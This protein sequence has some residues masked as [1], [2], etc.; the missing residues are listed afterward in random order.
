M[1]GTPSPVPAVV[2]TLPTVVPPIVQGTLRGLGLASATRNP[3]VPNVPTY[4]EM[5]FPNIY[6]GSWV[7]SSFLQKPPIP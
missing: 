4:G 7:A 6:S 2:L 5:G 1:I 3:A